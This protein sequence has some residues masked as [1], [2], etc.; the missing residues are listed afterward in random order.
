MKFN[1]ITNTLYADDNRLIKKMYCPYTT[2]KWNTLSSIVGS[3]DRFCTVCESSVVETKCMSDNDLLQ[4]LKDK[5]DTCLKVHFNQENI[6][7]V[8]NV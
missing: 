6:R 1:P 8:H 2:L 7:I 5:P 4:L 3:M